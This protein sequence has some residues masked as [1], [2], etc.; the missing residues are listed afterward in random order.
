M[1]V[2]IFDDN[3][4]KAI[5]NQFTQKLIDAMPYIVDEA[6]VEAM[7]SIFTIICPYYEKV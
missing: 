6:T 4:V 3:S 5:N 7:I 2:N 1:L